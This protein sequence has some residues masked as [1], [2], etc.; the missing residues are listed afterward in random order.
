MVIGSVL[1]LPAQ[2]VAAAGT[3]AS[4]D[5]EEAVRPMVL[6]SLSFPTTT[7]VAEAQ[8]AFTSGLLLLHLF[9]YRLAAIEFR[10]AQRLDSGFALAY[11]GEAMTYNHPI[12]DQQDAVAARAVLQRFGPDRATRLARIADDRERGFF[13]AVEELYGAGSKAERDLAHL[14]AMEDLAGRSPDDDEVQL[15]HALALFGKQAGVRDV[16]T[17]MQAAALA[18]RVFAHNPRHPGAA[19]YLIH[20]VDD[21][22][23]A[24]L[25]TDA[26]RALSK[27]APDSPHALH[28]T[29][30]IFLMLGLWDDVI[31][32][33]DASAASTNRW[34]GL[35]GIALRHTGHVNFWLLYALLQ[36]GRYQ[37]ARDLL[38][39]AHDEAMAPD[40]PTPPSRNYD[41]DNAVRASFVQMW[42]RYLL[43]TED[44]ASEMADWEVPLG[45]TPEPSATRAWTLGF[46]AAQ[47]GDQARAVEWS[48]AF[49]SYR[50][51][52][53]AAVN[54]DLEATPSDHIVLRRLEVMS[55]ELRSAIA[56]AGGD[57]AQALKEARQAAELES[58]MPDA[59]GPPLVDVPSREWLARLELKHG[60]AAAAQK[61]FLAQ[62]AVTRLRSRTLLGLVIAG[63]RVGDTD[64]A[65]R[66]RR[67]LAANWHDADAPVKVSLDSF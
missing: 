14:R 27:I 6:G 31:A 17:Y 32:A 5:A 66:A 29:S 2:A 52:I 38:R 33:N 57:A 23:H 3:G 48:K 55:H 24:I 65:D 11:W 7:K 4:T 61:H 54:A 34:C 39:I 51:R 20:A 49:E 10:R 36:Q 19:H 50:E 44:W 53:A 26:A 37:A 58:S 15:F 59:F 67:D 12:W 1:G 60:D 35:Q 45:E 13:T 8:E 46:R 28:M 41:P 56:D 18:Q 16:P 47:V 43:E 21:P 9:E 40:V 42:S 62:L 22:P 63:S 64:V 25:G 30:H